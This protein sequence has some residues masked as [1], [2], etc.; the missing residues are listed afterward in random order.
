MTAGAS[1]LPAS[2][3]RFEY[4]DTGIHEATDGLADARVM[5]VATGRESFADNVSRQN[6]GDVHFLFVLHGQLRLH[7]GVDQVRV[8]NA[9]DACVVPA[10]TTFAPEA[11]PQCEWLQVR[12]PQRD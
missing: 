8:L 6:A 1:W 7:S 10:D 4:R 11:N 2:D 9:D 3:P 12:V 5:R